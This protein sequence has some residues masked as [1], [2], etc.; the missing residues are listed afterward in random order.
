M[1]QLYYVSFTQVISQVDVFAAS[2]GR[3]TSRMFVLFVFDMVRFSILEKNTNNR[4]KDITHKI[5]NSIAT[6]REWNVHAGPG[7]SASPY[8]PERWR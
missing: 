5:P 4:T 2:I 7:Q 3:T 6:P 8:H 1:Y